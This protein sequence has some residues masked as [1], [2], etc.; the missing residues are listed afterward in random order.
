MP[1]VTRIHWEDYCSSTRF[2]PRTHIKRAPA[3][4]GG[5]SFFLCQSVFIRCLEWATAHTARGC[6]GRQEGRECGYYHL[7]RNL[8]DFSLFHDSSLFT[9]N[10]SLSLIS[11]TVARYFTA[12]TGVSAR[13][14]ARVTSGASA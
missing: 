6:D 7:H 4:C 1:A 8:N 12:A 14:A 10:S 5:S 2:N 11:V 13:V 9:L 3:E